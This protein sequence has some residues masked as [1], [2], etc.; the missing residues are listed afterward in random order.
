[1]NGTEILRQTTNDKQTPK[2]K[3]GNRTDGRKCRQR[4]AAQVANSSLSSNGNDVD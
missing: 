2:H 1:M 4:L 3:L